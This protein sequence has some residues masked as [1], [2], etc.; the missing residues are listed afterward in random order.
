MISISQIR[1]NSYLR[2]SQQTTPIEASQTNSLS[3]GNKHTN[4]IENLI[5]NNEALKE[6]IAKKNAEIQKL[7]RAAVELMKEIRNKNIKIEELNSQNFSLKYDIENLK[8][9]KNELKVSLE[10][11]THKLF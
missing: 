10:K 2:N 3:F 7:E 1:M 6:E 9:Q 11:L 8:K 5:K 4:K